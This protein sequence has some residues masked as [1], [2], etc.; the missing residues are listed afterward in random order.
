[1]E[2]TTMEKLQMKV[3]GSYGVVLKY[4]DRVFV[5]DCHYKGGFTADIYEMVDDPEEMGLADIECRL[6]LIETATERFIDNGH[7]IAW[8]MAQK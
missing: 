1:M 3:S 7:A 4:G 6:A 8:C 2:F 5:S